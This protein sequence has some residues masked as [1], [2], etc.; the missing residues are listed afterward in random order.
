MR[1]MIAGFAADCKQVI[2][3]ILTGFSHVAQTQNNARDTVGTHEGISA[4]VSLAFFRG[5]IERQ[6][7]Q[8][9]NVTDS[10][11]RAVARAPTV[12]EPVDSTR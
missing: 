8:S 5:F 9:G 6:R 12:K 7:V 10:P 11:P 3:K 2:G 4:F 1:G